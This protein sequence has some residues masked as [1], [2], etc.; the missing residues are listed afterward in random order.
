MQA[1]DPTNGYVDYVPQETAQNMGL[2][3]TDNGVAYM[4]VDYNRIGSGRGRAS[5]RLTSKKSYNHGLIIADIKHMPG[6]IC[7]AWP[8]L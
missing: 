2:I 4:G 8:A 3:N 1:Q 6:S 5:V 7:G